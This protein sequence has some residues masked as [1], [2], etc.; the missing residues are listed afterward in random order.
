METFVPSNRAMA[1]KRDRSQA[2]GDFNQVT[3][4]P[5]R[6]RFGLTARAR[7]EGSAIAVR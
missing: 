4:V 3:K 6:G 2:I 7:D 1:Y 5:Q